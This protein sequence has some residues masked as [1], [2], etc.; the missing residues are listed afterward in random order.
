M[1]YDQIYKHGHYNHTLSTFNNVYH[2]I[3]YYVT[4]IVIS[5]ECIQ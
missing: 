3:F 2:Y 5:N 4:Y 1:I